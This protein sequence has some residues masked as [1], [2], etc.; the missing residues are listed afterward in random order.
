[1]RDSSFHV[2]ICFDWFWFAKTITH[3]GL[4]SW[5]N[6]SD[7]SYVSMCSHIT[8]FSATP[9]LTTPVTFTTPP[10]TSPSHSHHLHLHHLHQYPS[11][12][13]ACTHITYAPCTPLTSS[14]PHP[15]SHPP[16]RRDG[17]TSGQASFLQSLHL[18]A[19]TGKTCWELFASFWGGTSVVGG[20]SRG[21]W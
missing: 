10:L 16:T 4:A 17:R 14:S 18:S 11:F 20:L 19:A 13:P 1:M 15:H 7:L 5:L 6:V 3:L 21:V 12:T 9:T 2:W 8:L